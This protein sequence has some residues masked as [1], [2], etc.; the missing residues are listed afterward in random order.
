MFKTDDSFRFLIFYDSITAFKLAQGTPEDPRLDAQ[1][2][3]SQIIRF[4]TNDNGSMQAE[5]ARIAMRARA[6]KLVL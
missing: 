2:L 5:L 6:C 3:S 1:I 4:Q